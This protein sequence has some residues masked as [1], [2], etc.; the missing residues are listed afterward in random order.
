MDGELS[1][2]TARTDITPPPGIAHAN[3][4]AQSHERAAGVDMTLWATALALSDGETTVVVVDLDVLYLWPEDARRVREAVAD[5]TD[6][7]TSNVRVSYTHTHSGPSLNRDTWAN[8]GVKMIDPYIAA[9][10]D[11]VSGVAWKAVRDLEPARLAA[12]S[13]TCD[14]A[15][16]RRFPR[17]EDGEIIVGRNPDGPVDH[18]VGVL[19]IDTFDGD[20]LATVVNYACH[21]ITVGPDNDL[22]TPDFPGQTKRTVESATG[23]TCLFLQGATGDVGPVRGIVEGGID[24]YRPLGH[25]LGHAASEVWWKLDPTGRKES[26]SETL[27]SGSPLAVYE[28]TYSDPEPLSF[29]VRTET[30]VLPVR[31]LPDPEALHVEY[32]RHTERLA[33]LRESGA[34]ESEISAAAK[35]A[36]QAEISV[37]FAE[38]YADREAVEIELQAFTLGEEIALVAVPGEPFVEIG[39]AV[40]EQ[41]PYE[42]T[43][44]SG[45][46]NAGI[47]YVPTA[48]AFLDGGYEV[49]ITPFAPGAAD[50]LVSEVV[51]ALAAEYS[52]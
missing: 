51:D 4:G 16:N 32:Q 45:Y 12:G 1:A 15:V 9:L 10:E 35:D 7:P 46:T 22:I 52:E 26:Y 14:I 48:D 28:T 44:F 8:A 6:L 38:R 41:S 5:V 21:P 39:R 2:A 13:G 37:G 30:A 29:G 49:E 42:H 20:P 23:S 33:T 50:T 27:P 17:P 24:E 3:W 36:R 11:D 31:D 43:F 47:A 19:R 18:G 25:R 34:D 40:K